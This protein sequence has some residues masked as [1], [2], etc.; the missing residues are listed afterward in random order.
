MFLPMWKLNT[1]IIDTEPT[2][3]VEHWRVTMATVLLPLNLNTTSS[4]QCSLPTPTQITF[5]HRYSSSR[6]QNY[7]F[8]SLKFKLKSTTLF[9]RA[10]DPD[11]NP[12]TPQNAEVDNLGVQ[13]A[14]SV[15]RFYKSKFF[16]LPFHYF[17]SFK[18]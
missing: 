3:E 8:N 12:Q 15:L 17:C 18:L 5:K 16:S 6:I 11:S 14:L 1:I 4:F 9:V 2:K 7:N 10:S 13:A